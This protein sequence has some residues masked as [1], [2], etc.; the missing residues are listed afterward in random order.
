MA[1]WSVICCATDFSDASRFAME[2]AADLA[3]A[4]EAEL[5]LVHVHDTRPQIGTGVIEWSR[6]PFALA[7]VDLE[8]DICAWRCEAE[9]RSGSRVRSAVLAGDPAAEI[10][11]FARERGADLLVVGKHGRTRLERFVL[12]S[13]AEKVV[14][15]APCP[16]LVVREKDAL[17]YGML[18]VERRAM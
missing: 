16:V 15:Q 7:A 5:V 11:R 3:R 12:G 2:E 4:F 1:G 17:A 18:P 10:V 14:R 9:K 13:V 6:L 8:R